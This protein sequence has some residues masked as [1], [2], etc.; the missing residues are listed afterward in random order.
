MG[1]NAKLM[2]VAVTAVFSLTGAVMAADSDYLKAVLS[3]IT[4]RNPRT[5]VASVDKERLVV[6][7]IDIVDS[8]GTIR[9]TLA[10][11]LPNPVVDGIEYKRQR[12]TGGLMIRDDHGNERGGFAYTP[13]FGLVL[14]IDHDNGEAAGFNVEDDGTVNMVMQYRPAQ[15]RAAELSNHLIPGEGGTPIAATVKPDG[16][17]E[18]SLQDKQD[19][20]RVV[21][22]V[23]PEGYGA[24][25][26]LDAK[27]KIVNTLVP[28]RNPG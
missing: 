5:R 1:P 27:G 22:T 7:R 25:E 11:D 9:M 8:R 24:I 12:P 10:G 19:R 3:L 2:F 21:I 16:T 14:G 28:E 23:T 13:G 4:D 15:R 17:P 20:P 18:L 26:F 6:R